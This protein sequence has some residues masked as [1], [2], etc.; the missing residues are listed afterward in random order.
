MNTEDNFIR[1]FRQ[2]I[3]NTI[4]EHRLTE[5][6][7]GVVVGVSGGPDSVCLLHVLHSLSED[8]DIKLTAVH[9]NHMLRGEEALADELYTAELC[10]KLGISMFT[11]KANVR[12]IAEKSGMSVEEAGREV[13]YREFRRR[14]EA[15]GASRIAVAHNRNDQAETV[16]MHIIRGTG[17][18]GLSGM[19]YRRGNVIRPLLG[20]SR[21]EIERY[22]VEAGL[23]FRTDS[24]NL[25]CEFSR[26]RIRLELFPYIEEKFGADIVES[27]CRL[28]DH[29][30]QDDGFLRRCAAT[31]YEKC[32][33]Q[34]ETGRVCLNLEQLGTLDPAILA[35]VF[36]QAVTDAA[37]SCSG[38]GDVHYT[39]LAELAKKGNTGMR[40]ELPGGLKAEVSYGIIK[41]YTGHT[42][43]AGRAETI[44]FGKNIAVPGTTEIPELG[45]SVKSFVY[46]AGEVDKSIRMGYN[47]FVQIF[48][49]DGLS[50]GI[51]IRNRREGDIFKP[52]GSTGTKKLKKYFIDKKIPREMRGRIP[53]VCIGGEVIWIIGHKI[54]DKF[55]VTENTKSILKLE[56]NRRTL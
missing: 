28:S 8:L 36:R 30:A 52:V 17:T 56:Y 41:I 18:T 20:T 7:C 15:V 55:K 9:V 49:Y 46:N 5:K 34:K 54:S 38:V 53:L 26:N 1:Q 51:H 3:R 31:A 40:A 16:M 2:K 33:T 10:E 48:D 37:G 39:A 42:T 12:A 14:A 47:S 32:R 43:Y 23:H 4:L 29:A 24:T 13:R 45:A 27:L 11:V 22:C 6:G 44:S 19:E 35:R 25:K 21:N 50:G